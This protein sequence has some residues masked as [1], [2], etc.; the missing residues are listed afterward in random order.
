VL[1]RTDEEV[2]AQ[3]RA[4]ANGMK[5]QTLWS[6]DLA[7][8][9]DPQTGQGD[10]SGADFAILGLVMLLL[11]AL[12][13][14]WIR[15]RGSGDLRSSAQGGD[16]PAV[17]GSAGNAIND[18]QPQAQLS[19]LLNVAQSRFSGS[20]LLIQACPLPGLLVRIELCQLV[21]E[22]GVLN[23]QGH[24]IWVPLP[25][26]FLGCIRHITIPRNNSHDR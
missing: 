3:A 13:V 20:D 14:G 17:P 4:A 2:L 6:G 24:Q 10:P 22:R 15:R 23:A 1:S 19:A 5:F 12:F 16:E 7:A 8:Y 21:G 18:Q 9:R 26:F 25:F 11:L